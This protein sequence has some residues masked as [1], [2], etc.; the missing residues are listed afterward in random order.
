[1]SLS[2]PVLL[3]V[4]VMYSNSP[5]AIGAMWCCD[6]LGKLGSSDDDALF[7][8]VCV[9]LSFKFDCKNMNET[10]KYLNFG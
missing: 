4:L 3:R 7:L 8:G 5:P 1:M 10:F 2:I 9:S 6:W